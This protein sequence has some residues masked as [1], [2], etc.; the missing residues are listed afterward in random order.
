MVG[1]FFFESRSISRF[2]AII[3]ARVKYGG[4][5]EGESLDT[6]LCGQQAH[7][8]VEINNR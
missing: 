8:S 7:T 2:I 1:F 4:G 6:I 5:P 3:Q